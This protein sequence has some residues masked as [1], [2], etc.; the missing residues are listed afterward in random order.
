M[1]FKSLA[2]GLT[3]AVLSFLLSYGGICCLPTGF[4]FDAPLKWLLLCC[5]VCSLAGCFLFRLRHGS[6]VIACVLALL[7]GYLWQQGDLLNQTLRLSYDITRLFH[8]AYGFGYFGNRAAADSIVLPLIVYGGLAALLNSWCI[9]RRWTVLPALLFSA[10][11]LVLCLVVTDTVPDA[12]C[13]FLLLLG[14]L[15]LLLTQTVRRRSEAD[16]VRLTWFLSVPVAL[17]LALLFLVI[18][19]STY[20]KQTQAE[21]LK[22]LV[23]KAANHL[24]MVDVS[25]DGE[26]TLSFSRDIPSQVNLQS[27]GPNTQFSLRIMDVTAETSEKLYLRGRHYNTYTGTQWSITE[28]RKETFL[29][30]YLYGL[31]FDI[32]TQTNS[33]LSIRT[34]GSHSV[35]YLPYHPSSPQYLQGGALLNPNKETD[36]TYY[37]CT[38]PQDIELQAERVIDDNYAVSSQAWTPADLA[39]PDSTREWAEEYFRSHVIYS[40]F[41]ESYYETY[42][43]TLSATANAI[44]DLVRNSASYD[45]NTQRMP[46]SYQDFAQWFLEESE[47]GYCVHYATATVVLLRAAGIPARYVEGYL[48]NTVAGE[49]V[50]VT[51]LNAHAWAEYYIAG[52]G[53]IPLES[54]AAATAPLPEESDP[55]QP[56]YAAPETDE[57]EQTE[58][59]SQELPSD[60]PEHDEAPKNPASQQE[61]PKNSHAAILIVP[62][63]LALLLI[64]WPIRLRLRHSLQ[65]TGSTN[66]QALK[67][68]HHARRL[69]ALAKHPLPD[70]LTELAL[71]AKFS[72]HIL[73]PADLRAFDDYCHLTIAELKRQPWWKQLYFRL[74]RAAY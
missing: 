51:G 25:E 68:W 72:Q 37:W 21:K 40:G 61:K 8:Q 45:L 50:T 49:T 36:Y 5:G 11:P 44:A 65:N 34:F 10:A 56:S 64:Q 17:L 3:A 42:G 1:K 59:L 33:T 67:K 7:G 27:I 24:P 13:L 71:R 60:S 19:Q 57:P 41:Y 48:T 53:W 55:T 38:L 39:L 18:P 29:A 14:L 31:S 35:K 43:S 23:I 47:T 66:A 4:G 63:V 70:S 73:T 22:D 54:T 20:N 9:T 74:I 32:E 69:A 15:L 28:G 58:P 6:A 12:G 26:L 52:I 62:V 2:S 46:E 30:P 16:S